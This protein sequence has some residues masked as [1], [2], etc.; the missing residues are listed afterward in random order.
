M[1]ITT[2]RRKVRFYVD[3][4][5]LENRPIIIIA[6]KMVWWA[7]IELNK[8]K[9]V[10]SDLKVFCRESAR[11]L[12]LA[13]CGKL[14]VSRVETSSGHLLV[15]YTITLFRITLILPL[16]YIVPLAFFLSGYHY[17]IF[18]CESCKGFFKRT[19][20]N[21]KKYFCHQKEGITLINDKSLSIL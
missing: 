4:H 9:Y 15:S 13:Y 8:D 16:A 12:S 14:S 3:I 20:Q 7:T 21:K 10:R 17:G 6:N 18:T 19:V 2:L 11:R 5:C 1:A